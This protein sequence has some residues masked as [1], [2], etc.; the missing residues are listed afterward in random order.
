MSSHLEYNLTFEILQQWCFDIYVK[1][2]TG[3]Q[4]FG[5]R[6]STLC[7]DIRLSDNITQRALAEANVYSYRHQITITAGGSQRSD[8]LR[9]CHPFKWSI[10]GA[11]Y[12]YFLKGSRA[13]CG[14]GR[15]DYFLQSTCLSAMPESKE[16]SSGRDDVT[17]IVFHSSRSSQDLSDVWRLFFPAHPPLRV[18]S[19]VEKNKKGT[20]LQD[21]KP[22]RHHPSWE[23]P[24]P[25]GL[26]VWTLNQIW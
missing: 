22:R 4:Q 14:R 5:L 23:I 11:P 10:P 24:Q 19:T 18:T 20:N 2:N 12:P 16:S 9:W 15:R 3:L 21:C 6:K 7:D 1:I 17:W 13:W 25:W 8:W 26:N